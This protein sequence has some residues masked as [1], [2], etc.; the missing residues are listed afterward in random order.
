[1]LALIL[2]KSCLANIASSCTNRST[3]RPSRRKPQ[4]MGNIGCPCPRPKAKHNAYAC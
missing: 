1:M 3:G 2:R 4:L